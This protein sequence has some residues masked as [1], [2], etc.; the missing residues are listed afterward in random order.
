MDWKR[1][2]FALLLAAPMAGCVFAVSGD[3]DETEALRDRVRHLE[4]RIERLE[5]GD[6]PADLA[7]PA[8]RRAGRPAGESNRLK[9]PPAPPA[10]PE[11]PAPPAPA[12]P[13]AP[14]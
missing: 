8:P 13:G 5:H 12:G 7:R 11:P 2:G 1:R 14:R 10:P 3:D 6:G 4:H 9:P